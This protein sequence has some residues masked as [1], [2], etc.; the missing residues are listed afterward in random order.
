[1]PTPRRRR[2]ATQAILLGVGL[3]LLP[4][5]L[6]W[7]THGWPR[8]G[9]RVFVAMILEYPYVL[10][11]LGVLLILLGVSLLLDFRSKT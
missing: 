7:L 1:M 6:S 2:D 11:G 3:L 5:L 4:P 8:L 9:R 10:Y